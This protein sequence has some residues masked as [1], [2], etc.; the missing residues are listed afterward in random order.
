MLRKTTCPERTCGFRRSSQLSGAKTP[1]GYPTTPRRDRVQDHGWPCPTKIRLLFFM[2]WRGFHGPQSSTHTFHGQ[3]PKNLGANLMG[4]SM[5][6]FPGTIGHSSGT[7]H[8]K[9][10]AESGHFLSGLL[11]DAFAHA[12]LGRELGGAGNL[13]SCRAAR[14][15]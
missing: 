5:G 6:L 8:P 12:H 9:I 4:P 13:F 3:M 11:G 14:C 7:V 15:C 1:V 2:I 10:F